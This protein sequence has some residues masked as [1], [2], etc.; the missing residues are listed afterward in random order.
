MLQTLHA[1]VREVFFLEKSGILFS[2]VNRG[3]FV[4]KNVKCSNVLR[5][6]SSSVINHE[7][8]TMEEMFACRTPAS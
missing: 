5:S 6:L 3:I 4:G 2:L 1:V 7:M 8:R